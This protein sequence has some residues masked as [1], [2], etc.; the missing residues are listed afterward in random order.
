[1]NDGSFSLKRKRWR[2]GICFEDQEM[3]R[4]WLM[5]RHGDK[6]NPIEYVREETD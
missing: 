5:M 3:E 4:A 2:M 1:M 6:G